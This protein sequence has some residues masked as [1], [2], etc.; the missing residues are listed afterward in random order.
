MP[1]VG[2]NLLYE[3]VC[4]VPYQ[5]IHSIQAASV[6]ASVSQGI[7]LH[8]PSSVVQDL[9]TRSLNRRLL[10]K[11][12]AIFKIGLKKVLK[13]VDLFSQPPIFHPQAYLV[14][15]LAF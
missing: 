15:A 4:I 3:P 6:L 8:Q 11:F 12:E 10:I 9:V 2:R 14:I 1:F 7:S 5:P 13:T